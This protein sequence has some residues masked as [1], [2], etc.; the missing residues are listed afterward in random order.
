[1]ATT[2]RPVWGS[3]VP[4]SMPVA[5][6]EDVMVPMFGFG[7]TRYRLVHDITAAELEDLRV[8]VYGPDIAAS[9]VADD[10]D[11]DSGQVSADGPGR[12]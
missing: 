11:L 3:D 6:A 2:D 8:P 9:A 12:A 4:I 5:A 10:L 1:M 7:M